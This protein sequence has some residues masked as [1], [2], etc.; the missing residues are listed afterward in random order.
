ML[1]EVCSK[2]ALAQESIFSRGGV[3]LSGA[4]A[5]TGNMTDTVAGK[6]LNGFELIMVLTI[7]LI[8]NCSGPVVP[9]L[10]NCVL[11]F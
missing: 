8:K 1:S 5:D 3:S 11:K 4:V 2:S 7:L 9:L 6:C 10:S